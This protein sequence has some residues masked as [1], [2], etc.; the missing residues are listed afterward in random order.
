MARQECDYYDGV[1]TLVS[2]SSSQNVSVA[3]NTVT[4]IVSINITRGCWIITGTT[5]L[6]TNAG[7]NTGVLQSLIRVG[8]TTLTMSQ[9]AYMH[10]TKIAL[11]DIYDASGNTTVKLCGYVNE[12]A[13]ARG[14]T[15]KAVKVADI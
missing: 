15:L 13:V 3:A 1:G 10:D 12:A 11:C 9:I 7:N 14:G 2:N 5:E 8:N 4:D 6:A